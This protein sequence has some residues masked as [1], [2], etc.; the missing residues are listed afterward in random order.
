MCFDYS[1]IL[2]EYLRWIKH[3]YVGLAIWNYAG[4][5]LLG[6]SIF[7]INWHTATKHSIIWSI[8]LRKNYQMSIIN[9]ITTEYTVLYNWCNIFVL[10]V[11]DFIYKIKKWQ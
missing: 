3:D 4:K 2:W 5:L 1:N 7:I 11:N 8:V 9:K 10:E 6:N